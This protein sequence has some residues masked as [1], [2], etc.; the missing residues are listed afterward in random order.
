MT[1]L[2][3]G[4]YRYARPAGAVTILLALVTVAACSAGRPGAAA[5]STASTVAASPPAASSPPVPVPTIARRAQT[6]HFG[7][8]VVVDAAGTLFVS[9]G[10]TGA[11]NTVAA[12][13]R[14]TPWSTAVRSPN[15][16]KVLPDG[17]HV[18]MEQ[19]SVTGG[20][21]ERPAGV[22][23]LDGD[24]RLLR[25]IDRD[26]R[27]RPFNAPNDVAVDP[28]RGGFWF[29]D[30]GPFGESRPGRVFR[31]TPDWQVQ[32]VVDGDAAYPN[33]IVL[34][35]DG[36]TLFVGESLANRVVAFPVDGDGR[37]GE[38]RVF[39]TLPSQPNPWTGG[40]AQ[41]D[42]MALDEQG[43]LYVCHFGSG[44]VRVFGADGQL[45]ASLG[46]GASSVTN[47]AFTGPARDTLVV[48]AAN[49]DSLADIQQ[50]GR[51]V[52]LTL[53]GTAGIALV[54]RS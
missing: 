8:G 50:G 35:P 33:G 22:A 2:R 47:L 27:G 36:R 26:D 1:G 39:A 11:V 16:H 48:A 24:G 3:S 37:L 34:R 42:G 44:D 4:S 28:V 14:I 54:R 7:E 31:V 38:R 52:A 18:V 15:G 32:T 41:P 51:L 40:E 9:D 29:T 5:A 53:P 10:F 13:G 23:H 20:T 17:T 12:D 43:R 30:P 25:L 19:G 21:P 49:G 6:Q 46:S 45:L